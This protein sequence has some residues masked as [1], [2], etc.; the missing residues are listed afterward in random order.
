MKLIQISRS[1]TI[2]IALVSQQ[3]LLLASIF[4]A[5]VL[6]NE[7]LFDDNKRIDN[8][9]KSLSETEFFSNNNTTG[10]VSPFTNQTTMPITNFGM[11]APYQLPLE[12][13][14]N[15]T[16]QKK[17][18]NAILKQGYNEYYFTMTDFRSKSARSLTENLLQSAD[19]TKLKIIIILLPPS[20]A[21]PKGNFDWNGWINYLNL[22]KTKYPSSLDGFVIDDFNLSN[23]SAHANK[24]RGN[25][26]NSH[27]HSKDNNNGSNRVPKENVSFMLK[28]KLAEALQKKR[29]DLHFYPVLYFEGF[30][31]NDVKRHYYNNTDGIVLASTNYY[32]VTD[33]DHN[34][35]VFS[36]VFNDKPIRYVVYSARTSNYIDNSPPSD[37]LIL[38]TLSIANES[39]LVKGVI[40][41]RNTHSPV[42]RDYLSNM[43][44]TEYISLV[45]MMEKL[46]LKDENNSNA[47]GLYTP[48]SISP[49]QEEEHQNLKNSN[50]RDKNDEN[51]SDHNKIKS[52]PSSQ[53]P[54]SIPS[55]P[56]LGISTFDLTPSIAEDMKL[57]IKSKG[58]VVQT[59]IPGSPA[60]NAGLKG[61]ILD[62]DKS[63]YLIRRGDVIISV[64]GH[65]VNEAI[66]IVK[67]MKK[68]HLGDLLNLVVDR[69][70]QILNMVTKL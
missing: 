1:K 24:G 58:A 17:A 28:S 34:L 57:P 50:N 32:N 47:Y 20:E 31:T 40:I 41:W 33:L 7:S 4:V 68:K 21:G 70:G 63:G 69:N 52:S 15:I 6:G 37:R 55:T 8:N 22:L 56:R 14:K 16:E 39:N 12:S 18:V 46:Q 66:D 62:V 27:N 3:L 19:G 51:I 36:K 5:P 42:I 45:S 65:K 44:N 60:Y 26:D 38:S 54:S 23:D 30:K 25:N 29:K 10:T 13:I 53:L 2:T 48:P 49:K 61:S 35:K 67:Q 43:N 9:V 64:D 59:V 11:W